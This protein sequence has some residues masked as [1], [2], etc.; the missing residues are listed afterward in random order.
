MVRILQQSPLRLLGNPTRQL[1]RPSA[2]TPRRRAMSSAPNPSASADPQEAATPARNG[3]E[4][5]ETPSHK[6]PLPLPAPEHDGD[7]TKL[8][9]GG[10]GVKLDH[11]GPLVVNE[12]GTM[13]RIANWNEMAEIERQNTLRVLGRRNK[14]RLDALKAKRAQTEGAAS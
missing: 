1:Y 13:S 4:Q 11:L 14:L 7:P 8:L 12:D 6:T 2:Y 9:V 3:N 10:E 5:Q